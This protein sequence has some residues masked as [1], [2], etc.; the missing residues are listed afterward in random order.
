MIQMWTPRFTQ[1]ATSHGLYGSS[2]AEQ[3]AMLAEDYNQAVI[4]PGIPMFSDG[5]TRVRAR[6]LAF[7]STST[8]YD[9]LLKLQELVL[10]LDQ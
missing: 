1:D 5:V 10:G 2:E 9:Q 6:S 7:A 3:E 4:V 8:S